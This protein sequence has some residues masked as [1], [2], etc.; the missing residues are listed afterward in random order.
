MENIDLFYDKGKLELCTL[1]TEPTNRFTK[2]ESFV[3]GIISFHN[4]KV[5]VPGR[6]TD[7]I[8]NSETIGLSELEGREVVPR[9]RRRHAVSST[10]VV[11]TISLA[12]SLADEYYPYQEY[13]IIEP[14]KE[15]PSAGIVGY[16]MYTS[17]FRIKENGMERAI[18]FIDEDAVTAA[19]EAGKLALIHAGIDSALIG[20][21]YVGT[22]SNPYAVKPI[23]SK[24]AQVLKLGKEEGDVQEVDAVDTEFACKAG[25]SMFKDAAALVNYPKLGM[26]YAMVIG[27]DNSQAAPRGCPG[28]ELDLFVGYGGAAYLFG[29]D[30]VIAEIEDW[31]SCTSDT[32]D[33]WRRDGEKHP[34]HGGRFTGDPA[35]FKHVRKASSRLM[36][37]SGLKASDI[38]YFVPHQPNP[39]FP[40][41]VAKELGF[42]PEQYELSLQVNKFGNT[43]SGC[44][45]VGLAAVLDVAKPDENILIASYGSGAGSDSYL[46]RT[47][48][49]ILDKRRRQKINVKYQT[50]SPFIEY[51]DYSTY[52]RLKLGM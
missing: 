50:E 42:K 51:V 33:F 31:Y 49:Q 43:Y 18:P 23:A 41:K 12:F 45:P 27:A 38:D 28:G 46:L 7:Q 36:E 25:T 3:Y 6:L 2:L 30:D 24:V 52:R 19:V 40:V 35:Y 5:R 11:P 15:Y 29:K 17:R 47:T 21:V 32:P 10:D 16:G 20:K 9:F 1:V 44:S 48:N 26:K 39:A 22:E 13:K 8:I 4:G 37:R 34:M 14:N